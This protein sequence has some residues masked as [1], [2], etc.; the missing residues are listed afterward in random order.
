[1]IDQ[2]TRPVGMPDGML[3]RWDPFDVF[4]TFAYEL[5][6]LRRRSPLAVAR[7]APHGPGA[8]PESNAPATGPAT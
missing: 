7:Q 5:E 6:R 1:M 3:A 4:D 8:L 2:T